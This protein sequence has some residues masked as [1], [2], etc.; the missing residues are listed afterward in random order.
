MIN[1]QCAVCEY[2]VCSPSFFSS[3]NVRR[4]S[5]EK[6]EIS[7]RSY[8]TDDGND[9]VDVVSISFCLS[10]SIIC[11][12]DFIRTFRARAINAD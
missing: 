11:F 8:Y 9:V 6:N 7:L 1:M 5:T 3:S 4:F 10:H 12:L 2:D